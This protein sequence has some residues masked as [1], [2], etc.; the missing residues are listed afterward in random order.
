M[1]AR[2]CTLLSLALLPALA[3]GLSDNEKAGQQLYR[4]GQA[5]TDSP[6]QARLEAADTVVDAS[7][8]PC[9]GCHGRDGRGRA[10]GGLNPPDITWARLSKPYGERLPGARQHPPYTEASLARAI[11]EGVDPGGNRLSPAMPRYSLSQRQVRDLIAYLQRIEED[12]DPGIS[13]QSL[14]LGTWQPLSG[15]QADGGQAVSLSLREAIAQINLDGGIH[16]RRLT[17]VVV[18]SAERDEQAVLDELL[19][20][21]EVFALVAVQT[22]SAAQQEQL[23]QAGVPLVGTLLRNDP[24]PGSAWTFEPL[25]GIQDQMKALG[26]FAEQ[27]LSA[28]GAALILVGPEPAHQAQAESL[29]RWLVQRGWPAPAIQ[30]AEAPL[31]LGDG[32]SALFL[33]GSGL[34]SSQVSLLAS[35]SPPPYL[36]LAGEQAQ[37]ELFELPMAFSARV[38]VAYPFLPDDWT[39]AFRERLA[40][41]RAILGNGY[42]NRR[43]SASVALAILEE[44]LRRAGRQ[45]SRE[46]LIRAL[47]GLYDHPTGMSPRVGFSGGRRVGAGAHIVRLDLKNRE[48]HHTGYYI[49]PEQR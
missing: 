10:E 29:S 25:A 24:G 41:Q 44:G 43:V 17:L 49:P 40:R 32:L 12:F 4:Y 39:P 21:H 33:L 46:A 23:R 5:N 36:L 15:A 48:L 9:A 31:V 45:L 14:V 7:L 38:F 28:R 1:C 22:S 30:G 37:A 13:D 34:S 11:R 42:L 2:L 20:Q 3:W 19:D 35:H 16:G 26:L 8:L 27:A 47:E 18:D 6:V